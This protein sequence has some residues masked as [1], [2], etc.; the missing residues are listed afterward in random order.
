MKDA[1][2]LAKNAPSPADGDDGDLLIVDSHEEQPLPHTGARRTEQ[3]RRDDDQSSLPPKPGR[4]TK[5]W[6]AIGSL[7]I[8]TVAVSVAYYL[9]ALG[10]ES[11][12]DAFIEGHVV[13]ISPRVAGHVAKVCV[14]DNDLV[15]AGQVLVELDPADFETRLAAATAALQAASAGQTSRTIGADVTQITSSAGVEEASAGVEGAKA[16]LDTAR[17]AVFTAQSQQAQAQALLTA[18]QAA[19]EQ[20][21]AE[22]R[23]AEA[24]RQLAGIYL[25]RIRDLAPKHAVSQESL[26]E[27]EAKDRVAEA[28]LAAARQRVSAQ[29]A[30]VK[31]AQAA[32]AATESSLHQA[33]SAVTARLAGLRRAEAMLDSAKSAPKQ[34]EQS[35]SQT[36]VA[37]AEAARARAEVRQAELNIGYTKIIAPVAGRVTRKSVEPGAYV[38]VGQPL[39]ALVE[40]NVWVVANFKETQLTKMRQNQAVSVAVDVYPGVRFAAHVDSIQRGSGAYF[41]LLPPENATGN[42]V[43]VVQRVPVKIMFDDPRQVEQ[44]SLGPGMSVVPTVDLRTVESPGAGK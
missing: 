40:P 29:Q 11:T 12:D 34:V 42:F 31:Q 39:L 20:A 32:V 14:N 3:P 1:K 22:V 35:H 36:N 18:A 28:Q 30:A 4:R 17:A 15:A 43:K 33:E 23:A 44:Y 16:E 7:V 37:K 21:Q 41:S 38:Q 6:V 2:L 8:V 27:A 9:Y 5:T 25:G 19:T 13:P 26:D 10:H 24:Q